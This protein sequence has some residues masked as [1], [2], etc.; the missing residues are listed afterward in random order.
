MPNSQASEPRFRPA[1]RHADPSALFVQA[2]L[3]AELRRRRARVGERADGVERER[4]RRQIERVR[5]ELQREDALIEP[6]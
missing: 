5:G 4:S 2:E 1:S 6:V 3:A